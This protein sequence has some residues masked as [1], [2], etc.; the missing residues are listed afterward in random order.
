[1]ESTRSNQAFRWIEYALIVLVTL[2]VW[3]HTL[4][5]G[6][7]WDDWRFIVE[8][9]SIQSFNGLPAMLGSLEGQSSLPEKFC[10]YRPV[11][12]V[13]WAVLVQLGGGPPANPVIFHA[14]NLIGHAL[15]AMLLCSVSMRLIQRFGGVSSRSSRIAALLVGL[16]FVVHPVVSEVICWAKSFDDILVA[17]F[18]LTAMSQL[19]SWK[20]GQNTR[21]WV[22]IGFFGLAVYSKE[23]GVSFALVT[24][25]YFW[26]LLR[27]PFLCSLKLSSGFFVI[28]AI[29][30]VHRH[31]VIGQTSQQEP[32]SGSYWQ[33][34]VDTI[35]CAVAYVRLALGIPPFN[36]AYVHLEQGQKLVSGPVLVGASVILLV[37]TVAV[38]AARS[39]RWKLAGFGLLWGAAFF[40]PVSNI[41][42]MMQFMAERFLYLP[43]IGF[44]LSGA[45]VLLQVAAKRIV[46]IGVCAGIAIWAFI[47]RDRSL[48]W[49]D[50]LTLFVHTS[51]SGPRHWVIENNAASAILRIPHVKRAILPQ[52]R[53]KPSE[54]DLNHS[55]QTLTTARK[56][57]PANASLAQALG[58]CWANRGDLTKAIE[59]FRDAAESNPREVTHCRSLARALIEAQRISEAERIIRKLLTVHSDDVPLN[60]MLC[61]VLVS[62]EQIEEAIA[63]MNRLKQ[64]D[65][66]SPDYDRW[67]ENTRQSRRKE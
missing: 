40:V 36:I 15:A 32:L 7:V 55:I 65:P 3:G 20:D 8:N 64:I 6:F 52:G 11:R 63:L 38:A 10:L 49:S 61:Q 67:I 33:T 62:Q 56:A 34:L 12:T 58:V 21:L 59:C 5:F 28:A 2:A 18:C 37:M 25:A 41:V 16:A 17:I 26:I 35:P 27:L 44:L 31:F 60:R 24:L 13:A 30:I 50:D 23:S 51:M 14:A 22:A 29:F 1:M 43:L 57:F 66:T 46:L 19:L 39:E 42:P 54:A 47:A 45:A 4:R 9:Q 48:V 53:E